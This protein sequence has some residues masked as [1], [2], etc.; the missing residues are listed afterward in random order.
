[1]GT[2]NQG[3]SALTTTSY[4]TITIP[5]VDFT[6]IRGATSKTDI[7]FEVYRT[8]A[9]GTPSTTGCIGVFAQQAGGTTVTDTGPI[10]PAPPMCTSLNPPAL[11]T[12]VNNF[13]PGGTQGP[14][15]ARTCRVPMD[16][17]A[18]AVQVWSAPAQT[19]ALCLQHA[20]TPA[21]S[22]GDAPST[23]W[24]VIGWHSTGSSASLTV[25]TSSCKPTKPS[26]TPGTDNCHTSRATAPATSYSGVLYYWCQPGAK[27]Q[28]TTLYII[29]SGGDASLSPFVVRAAATG[30]DCVA[31]TI[32]Q[33]GPVV[34]SSG[35]PEPVVDE[36]ARRMPGCGWTDTTQTLW[37]RVLP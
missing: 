29:N 1:V 16:T 21:F 18:N 31:T 24:G 25:S 22:P 20:L 30:T 34:T 3:P 5:H 36:A 15:A 7:S 35:H 11:L 27:S 2:D 12:L 26:P 19:V 10:S 8:T 6:S 32:G 13:G 9:G 28:V 33:A 14:L 4:E 37:N 23:V 17:V